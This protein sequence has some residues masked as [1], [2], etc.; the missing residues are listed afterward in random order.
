ML[1]Q[2]TIIGRLTRSPNLRYTGSGT[3]VANFT[4]AVERSFSNKDG[5]R[6]VDFIPVVVWQKLAET[7]SKHLEKG[8]LVCVVGRLQIRKSEKGDRTY[9]NPEIV[10]NDVR[11][12]DWGDKKDSQGS[13]ADNYDDMM[14][15]DFDVQVPF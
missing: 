4:L 2:C 1:N 7:C 13:Q 9:I 14:D 6:E 8:R 11:F 12:L 15:D 3:P 10:A 5:D